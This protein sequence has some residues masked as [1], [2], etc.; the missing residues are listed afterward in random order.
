MFT[1]SLSTAASPALP[2]RFLS[3]AF[4]IVGAFALFS[5]PVHAQETDDSNP[6]GEAGSF[7]G[8]VTTGCSY[9]P[10]TG[11][12]KRSV[13]DYAMVGSNGDYPLVMARTHNSRRQQLADWDQYLG[14]SNWRHSYQWSMVPVTDIQGEPTGKVYVGYPDGGVILFD[15]NNRYR[16]SPSQHPAGY[17]YIDGP[18]GTSDRLEWT[19]SQ[20]VRNYVLRRA[21][22]GQVVFDKLGS[23]SAFNRAA[24]IIDPHGAVTTLEYYSSNPKWLRKVTEPGGRYLLF[25]IQRYQYNYGGLQKLSDRINS[26]EAWSGPVRLKVIT[27]TYG[28]DGAHVPNTTLPMVSLK[29]VSYQD[30]A[31]AAHYTYLYDQSGGYLPLLTTARD[32][33]FGGPMADIAYDY[34]WV[35]AAQGY[36]GRIAAEKHYGGASEKV[37]SLTAFNDHYKDFTEARGDGASRAFHYGSTPYTPTRLPGPTNAHGYQL[38][39]ASDYEGTDL[40]HQT[41]YSYDAATGYR[42]AVMDHRTNITRFV[43]EPYTG[44]VTQ[45]QYPDTPNNT[46]VTKNF[47]YTDDA[48][49]DSTAPY[50]LYSVTDENNHKTTTWRQHGDDARSHLVTSIDYPDGG[51]ESFEY[52]AFPNPDG[53]NFYKISRHYTKTGA[54]I[55]Y[56]YDQPDHVTNAG[57]GHLGLLTQ[58][59]HPRGD[60]NDDRAYVGYWYNDHDLPWVTVDELNSPTFFLYNERNQLTRATHEDGSYVE[61]QYN[62]YGRKTVVVDELHHGTYYHYDDYWRVTEIDHPVDSEHGI[63]R[64]TNFTYERGGY[65]SYTHTSA[66]WAKTILSPS[67][68][69]SS[70]DYSNNGRVKSETTGLQADG[71]GNL[72]PTIATA[73]TRYLYDEDGNRTSVTV[74]G[75]N[76]QDY[77]TTST[78][79]ARNRV[80]SVTSPNQ[81]TTASIYDGVGNLAWITTPPDPAARTTAFYYDAMNRRYCTIDPKGQWNQTGYDTAGNVVWFFDG[82][83]GHPNTYFSYDLLGRKRMAVYQGTL[84]SPA[85]YE[86]WAYDGRGQ[87]L[88]YRNRGGALQTFGAPDVRKRAT[89]YD[90]DDGLTTPCSWS[91]DYAGKMATMSNNAS[92]LEFTYND[93]GELLDELQQVINDSGGYGAL[94]HVHYTRNDDGLVQSLTYPNGSV[95][96]YGYD[97]AQRVT[98]IGYPGSVNGFAGYTYNPDGSLAQ[99]TLGDSTQL[100]NFVYDQANRLIATRDWRPGDGKNITTRAYGY[101]AT[102]MLTWWYR[103]NDNGSSGS[104][105]ENGSG[106][107]YYYDNADQI[108][109]AVLNAFNVNGP[110]GGKGNS[111]A[112]ASPSGGFTNTYSYDAAGNRL[113]VSEPGTGVI[114]SYSPDGLNRYIPGVAYDTRGNSTSFYGYTCAYDAEGRLLTVSGNGASAVFN[115]DPK[116]RLCRR[117]N[118]GAAAVNCYFDGWNL[119]EERDSS[120]TAW[121][122]VLVRGAGADEILLFND[123]GQGNRWLHR[124]AVSGHVTA[125]TLDGGAVQERYLYDIYGTRYVYDAAGQGRAGNISAYANRYG[126][127]GLQHFPALNLIDMRARFYCPLMGRFLQPDPIGFAGGRNLYAYCANDPV[128]RGDPSGL[129]SSFTMSSGTEP[130]PWLGAALDTIPTNYGEG[131]DYGPAQGGGISFTLGLAYG[132]ERTATS[133]SGGAEISSLMSM[134]GIGQEQAWDRIFSLTGADRSSDEFNGGRISGVVIANGVVMAG[135]AGVSLVGTAGRAGAAVEGVTTLDASVI[136]FSQSNVR[137]SLP[138]IVASMRTNGWQGAPIDVVRM[139][140]GALTAADNTRLAAAAL[141]KTP[142]QAIIR[143][144]EE[145]FPA[146]RAGGNLQG[147]TWGEA[148]L[149]RIAGQRPAW[150]RLYPNGSTVTGAHPDTPVFSP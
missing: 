78:Y 109:H 7:N 89:R 125:L 58:V 26:V 95:V 40:A 96:Q 11:N 27:Y 65:G 19:Q 23:G 144:F 29:D 79:D 18:K 38:S 77:T 126:W 50:Y 75:A 52:A 118:N 141:T 146:A 41:F 37:S 56:T 93:Q 88:S 64:F 76:N 60:N 57:S 17:S 28:Q 102:N 121:Q 69:S 12:A 85:D 63:Y 43:T 132:I 51:H 99:R 3:A 62:D 31:A 22:G 135:T 119:I 36:Y 113:S 45:V 120:G 108:D 131:A 115:Y 117:A 98:G 5:T 105:T 148:I 74:T 142:V 90:W 73:V 33:H 13:V 16:H 46:N 133:L 147:R 53:T 21:D 145:L 4:A 81:G 122:R 110:V 134:A 72:T 70:R 1:P 94:N 87:M 139:A 8:Q 91:Y 140:D 39:S 137:S 112:S 59:S 136:R 34:D 42:N 10:Y 24:K 49:S 6:T 14:D 150:Q 106:E 114:G 149:N 100:D 54:R 83:N 103:V 101:K 129:D 9:D 61:T 128:N 67:G 32:P 127:R 123:N 107:G 111:Q 130:T 30:E 47:T 92:H 138:D 104:A 44:K 124:D 20:G 97:S 84:Q 80:F 86:T 25:N 82:G 48:H 71:G 55:E 35:A 66:A 68:K 2:S 143:G 116:G 15:T